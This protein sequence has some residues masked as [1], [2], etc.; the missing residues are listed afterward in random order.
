MYRLKPLVQHI[1]VLFLV[2]WYSHSQAAVTVTPAAGL[3]VNN[4]PG[5]FTTI[6]NIVIIE[7]SNGDFAVQAGAT[8]ILSAPANFEFL[9]GT[10]TVAVTTGRNINSPA[11]IVV[12]N[13]T[14]TITYTCTGTNKADRMTISGIQVRGLAAGSSGNILRTGGTGTITGDAAGG[15]V[16]HGTLS[17]DGTGL[18]VTSVSNGNWSSGST[19][20]TGQVPAC[21]MDVQ[22]SHSVTMDVAGSTGNVTITTGGDLTATNAITITGN[23]VIT[24][25]GTYRHNNTSSGATTVFAGT[26]NFAATSNLVF[27]QWYDLNVPLASL[28]SSTLGNIIFNVAGT[29]QQDGYFAPARVLGNIT[30]TSGTVV[31][32]DGTGMSTSLT[33]QDVSLSGTGN[34][35]ACSGTNR[36]FTFVTGNFTDNGTGGTQTTIMSSCT[37]TLSWTSLG[38]VTLNDNFGLIISSGNPAAVSMTTTGDLNITGGSIDF[39]SGT[40]SPFTLNIGGNTNISGTPGY[41]NFVNSGS[42]AFIYNTDNLNITATGTLSLISGSF[43]GI[44]QFNIGQDLIVNNN[45][46][47]LYLIN[48]GGYTE[49][50]DL[51]TGR[52]ILLSN[53][54]FFAA[55][56][57]GQVAV[58]C[59]RNLQITGTGNQFNG[60]HNSSNS[61][62]TDITVNGT[63]SVTNGTYFHTLGEGDIVLTVG[64]TLIIDNGYFYGLDHTTSPALATADFTFE[65]FDFQGGEV[66]L[67]SLKTS[68]N[69]LLTVNCI[70]NFNITW[71]ANTDLVELISYD[72][73]N[74]ALLDMFVGGSFTVSGNYPNAYFLS[75]RAG[76]DESVSIVGNFNVSGGN[77]FFV[78]DNASTNGKDA[79]NIVSTVQGDINITGGQT[80]LSTRDGTATYDIDGNVNISSGIMNLKWLTGNATMNIDGNYN[81]TGGTFNFHSRAATID[82]TIKVVVNG[83]FSQSAGTLNFDNGTGPAEHTLTFYSPNVTLSGSAIITHANNLSATWVFG[84]IYFNRSGTTIF[85]RSTSTHNIQH[86][87]QTISAGTT[88]NASSSSSGFQM[89][90]VSSATA[91]IHNALTINGTLD[92]GD[93]ILSA[94]Q[95]ANYYSQVTVNSGGR[96]RTSHTGGLYSGSSLTASSINGFI[97]ALNRV[98]Y[99]L[100]ANSTVE[101]YGTS[102]SVVTGVPN[103]IATTTNQQYGNLEINFTGAAGSTWVYPE[104]ADEVHIRTA[105]IL[106]E[107]EFNLDNNHN[108]ASGGLPINL[109]TGATASRTNGFIRSETEDG[110]GVVRWNITANGSYT[111]PFG[112]DVSNYI[113]FMFQQTSG[114]AGRI[115]IGTYRTNA[116]NLPYPPTVTHVRDLNGVNNSLQTVDRFWNMS[117]PGA[118]GANLLFSYVPSEGAGIISPRAQLWEPVSQGWFLPA[119][120]QSNPTAVTTLANIQSSFNTWWTLSALASPLPI[121]LMEFLAKKSGEQVILTWKTQT[122]I[123]NDFFT[124]ERSQNGLQFE[125][126]GTVSGAGTSNNPN[127]YGMTDFHPLK[128]K[129]YYRLK[130]TDYDGHFT[131]SQNV[132]ISF[133]PVESF[134][135]Y[136][137]PAFQGNKIT[138]EF[139]E[140]GNYDIS[141]TA[142]DGKTLYHTTVDISNGMMKS[143]LAGFTAAPGMYILQ[144][145]GSSGIHSRKITVK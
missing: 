30:I 63:L 134:S 108:T 33:L 82:D 129:S 107:G 73:N 51:T 94:R 47:I 85:S 54:D 141:I 17:S 61:E 124:V 43:S 122:E 109:E 97:S 143:D 123:N 118:A 14:I 9:A 19:W 104:T 16:N 120:I 13:N 137:N 21:N 31:M 83:D 46:Q 26:E 49:A 57:N 44:N 98:N 113:P 88:V 10:G 5:A 42:G 8:I 72:G 99:Y 45:A 36:N 62:L 12:T 32:D 111:I 112:Y 65:D 27:N 130:Q 110:S 81:Q 103:G 25:T 145:F 18:T 39:L 40:N 3:C 121:E 60:Q 23:F 28:I 67:F 59:G 93:K 114:N 133:E 74:D 139:P 55:N 92:M 115:S 80:F 106:T 78:C 95:Q 75:S 101:Y 86:V 138:V 15:G 6:S 4:T 127:S 128:G 144:V 136:P 131:Y 105:L 142:L 71:E 77:V 41:V 52:D 91:T 70:N 24:G 29:W 58:N 126:L 89:T 22:I 66:K 140:E 69:T 2:V 125:I 96:Y 38:N 35:I 79:H 76:G 102:T 100:N 119:G 68:S 1:L 11:A 50:L 87:R 56:T 84:H 53:G 34:L 37:G 132:S 48:I 116:A 117:V 135:V 64:E 90:S 20:S 7:G